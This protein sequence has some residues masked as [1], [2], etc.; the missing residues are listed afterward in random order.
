MKAKNIRTYAERVAKGRG[1]RGF[2]EKVLEKTGGRGGW[3]LYNKHRDLNPLHPLPQGFFGGAPHVPN[4][5]E[6]VL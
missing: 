1:C 5:G 6:G 4:G 3:D 2:D